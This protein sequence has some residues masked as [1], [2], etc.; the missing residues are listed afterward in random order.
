M[1]IFPHPCISSRQT[2]F[3]IIELMIAGTLTLLLSLTLLKILL[4]S[5]HMADIMITQ[6]TL[7]AE[8]R[9]VFELLGEGGIKAN[10]DPGLSSDRIPGYHGRRTDPFSTTLTHSNFQL[11]LGTLSTQ[12]ATPAE[13]IN[14]KGAND[15]VQSC[16]ASSTTVTL[17]G[18]VDT[19]QSIS[20]VRTLTANPST[21]E[22]QFT[23]INPY[24]VPKDTQT[25]QFTQD[26]YSSTFWT[27]FNR[28]V[29][30]GS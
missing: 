28:N 2:G 4:L 8:A 17:G 3:T 7:N 6:T 18:A 21:T 16:T 26:E 11:H 23:I 19:F 1:L 25:P 15:R 22:V 9:A 24:R 29:E 20:N 14:C 30:T 12:A 13:I 5:Q 27:I 10:G